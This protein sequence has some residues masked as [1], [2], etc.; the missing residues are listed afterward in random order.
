MVKHPIRRR[1]IFDDM[2]RRFD[3][4]FSEPFFRGYGRFFPSL[5]SEPYTDMIETDKEVVFTAEILGV[6]KEDINLNV[7]EDRIEV[8][9][10]AKKEKEKKGKDIYEYE[11]RYQGFRSS[12]STPSPINPNA[13]KAS[14]KNGVLEVRA[15]KLKVAKGR[16]ITVQ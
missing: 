14:F 11:G 6:K 5:L 8:S 7:T 1:D 9:V 16:K 12:Y 2:R 13:V 10:E 4:V 15:P 3:D